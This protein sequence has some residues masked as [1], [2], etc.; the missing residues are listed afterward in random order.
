VNGAKSDAK[1]WLLDAVFQP[2]SAA[3]YDEYYGCED[4][5]VAGMAFAPFFAELC[6]L[7]TEVHRF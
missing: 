4:S 3:K 5:I 1:S 2:V 6:G 7:S